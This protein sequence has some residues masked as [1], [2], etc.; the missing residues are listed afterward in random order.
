M[1]RSHGLLI[2][3][4]QD[5]VHREYLLQ[6]TNQRITRA[7]DYIKRY[8]L[9]MHFIFVLLLA[10]ST[11]VDLHIKLRRTDMVIKD[12]EETLMEVMV[13]C[14]L[15]PATLE[16]HLA[17]PVTPDL[18]FIGSSSPKVF[19]KNCFSQLSPIH[20]LGKLQRHPLNLAA[21]SAGD[22][23]EGVYP[24]QMRRRSITWWST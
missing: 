15:R 18:H 16:V 8:L 19:T 9:K 13:L 22:A 1:I 12:H 4:A 17:V 23:E 3:R 20:E 11:L 7:R 6:I 2:K 14:K 24:G 5:K 21:L 10:L